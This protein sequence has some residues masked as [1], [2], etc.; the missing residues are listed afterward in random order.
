MVIQGRP[1]IDLLPESWLPPEPNCAPCENTVQICEHHLIE[2][3]Q[4]PGRQGFG[5]NLAEFPLEEDRSVMSGEH[6][7]AQKSPH[8]KIL[9]MEEEAS[10]TRRKA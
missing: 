6:R 5:Y 8:L 2:T 4:F 1:L 10:A 7:G 9:S 3:D